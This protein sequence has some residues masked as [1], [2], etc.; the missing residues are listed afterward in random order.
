MSEADTLNKLIILYLL[1]EAKAPLNGSQISDCIVSK[2]YM[3]YFQLRET[4][5][6]LETFNLVKVYSDSNQTIY[7][8][9]NNG[10]RTIS[11]FKNRI[12]E[13]IRREI[14]D[15]LSEHAIEFRNKTACEARYFP[16]TN[17]EF[18]VRM[19]IREG[20][21]VLMELNVPMPTEEKAESVT[22]NFP[23]R[24]QELY[25]EIMARLLA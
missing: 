17:G 11:Y 14:R 3:Q 10:S 13:D 4:L 1:D 23:Q 2:G 18:T 22:L 8:L 24:A 20:A 12:S 6:E 16:T 9:D 5:A 25:A 21:E 15:Y 7:E 19:I